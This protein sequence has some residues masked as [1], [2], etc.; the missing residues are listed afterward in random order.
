MIEFVL[1]FCLIFE[2]ELIRKRDA[3]RKKKARES[4]KLFMTAEQKS[5]D[6]F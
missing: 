2:T 4:A 6:V 1:F 5:C 3:E